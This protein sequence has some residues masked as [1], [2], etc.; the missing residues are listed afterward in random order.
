M[1]NQFCPRIIS[2]N[3]KYGTNNQSYSKYCN[4]QDNLFHSLIYGK[5]FEKERYSFLN[6]IAI[7]SDQRIKLFWKYLNKLNESKIGKLNS[8]HFYNFV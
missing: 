1:H 6:E 7:S 2:K 5:Y 8:M 4:D 3:K